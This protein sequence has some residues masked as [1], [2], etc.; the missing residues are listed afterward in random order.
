MD[1]TKTA[2]VFTHSDLSLKDFLKA[3]CGTAV[4]SRVIPKILIPTASGTGSEWSQV[5]VLHDENRMGL[6]GPMEQYVADKVITDPDLTRN[7]PPWREESWL[8]TN[9]LIVFSLSC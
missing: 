8:K 9:R 6:P 1:A 3:P 7:L 4:K 5:V 2:S